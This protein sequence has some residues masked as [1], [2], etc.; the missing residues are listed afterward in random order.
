MVRSTKVVPAS[1]RALV[2]RQI[3]FA[4]DALKKAIG[5]GTHVVWVDETMLT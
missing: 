1:S 5:E 4:R 2:P 3:R